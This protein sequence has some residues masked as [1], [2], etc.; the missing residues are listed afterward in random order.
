MLKQEFRQ[1]DNNSPEAIVRLF[2]E[3]FVPTNPQFNVALTDR[4][5]IARYDIINPDTEVRLLWTPPGDDASMQVVE[6]LVGD[7]MHP[8]FFPENAR[9][10][11][12]VLYELPTSV[13][14]LTTTLDEAPYIPEYMARL[15]KR[16]NEF[17]GKL[18]VLD[19]GSFGVTLNDLA[20]NYNGTD[21]DDAFFAILPPLRPPRDTS[22]VLD[23]AF[24][25]AKRH[26]LIKYIEG[27]Q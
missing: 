9:D 23:E 19:Q 10:K 25:K 13:R 26:E 27:L 4:T 16:A 3:G 18:A 11:E 2:D 24:K 14:L 22:V 21:G 5:D 17:L 8:V 7:R 1:P 12:G 20:I 6:E 15:E